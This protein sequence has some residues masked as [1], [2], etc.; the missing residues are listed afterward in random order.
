MKCFQA[1]YNKGAFKF[2]FIFPADYPFKPPKLTMLTPI[3]HPNIDEKGQIWNGM[4]NKREF[5]TIQE[6]NMKSLYFLS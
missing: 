6:G 3:Y 5:N 2:Q 1:P 4:L